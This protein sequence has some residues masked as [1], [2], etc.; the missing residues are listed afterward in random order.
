MRDEAFM[1]ERSASFWI[2]R[3]YL[4]CLLHGFPTMTKIAHVLSGL[5]S[6]AL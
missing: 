6:S 2:M 3:G 1:T 5:R 4:S